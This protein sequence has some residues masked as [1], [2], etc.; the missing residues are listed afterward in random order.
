MRRTDGT[1][2]AWGDNREGQL[3]LGSLA[4]SSSPSR[5]VGLSGVTEIAAGGRR[6]FARS[7]S[8]LLEWGDGQFAPESLGTDLSLASLGGE[9]GSDRRDY[10][11]GIARAFYAYDPQ[12]NVRALADESGALTDTYTYDAFGNLLAGTH[13]GGLPGADLAFNPYL[14][15][16]ERY[17]AAA[18]LYHLR[19][20]DCDPLLGR[21]Q[22]LDSFAGVPGQPFSHNR[23][24]YSEADPVNLHDPS[25]HYAVT[26]WQ[27]VQLLDQQVAYNDFLADIGPKEQLLDLGALTC[28]Y[29]YVMGQ[30]PQ[31]VQ[32]ERPVWLA[33]A[34]SGSILG[35]L[36]NESGSVNAGTDGGNNTR[37]LGAGSSVF[38]LAQ[39]GAPFRQSVV[40]RLVDSAWLATQRAWPNLNT[41]P[42]LPDDFR[43]KLSLK[44]QNRWPDV[45]YHNAILQGA[46]RSA[47]LGREV[48]A[49]VTATFRPPSILPKTRSALALKSLSGTAGGGPLD[50]RAPAA[51]AQGAF[52]SHVSASGFEYG[53]MEMMREWTE[54]VQSSGAYRAAYLWA[55]VGVRL[56][57]ELAYLG[58]SMVS[59]VGEGMDVHSAFSGETALER[60]LAW[61][62]LGASAATGGLSPN[63]G[64]VGRAISEIGGEL[65]RLGRRAAQVAGHGTTSALRAAERASLAA[66]R[67]GALAVGSLAGGVRTAG[68]YAAAFEK[69]YL[70][71]AAKYA[72]QLN[73]GVDPTPFFHG[74]IEGAREARALHNAPRITAEVADTAGDLARTERHAT[75]A[76]ADAAESGMG[77][78]YIASDA[79]YLPEM[80]KT[81]TIPPNPKGTYFSLDK[82]D[83]ALTASRLQ[84]PHDAAIRAEFGLAQLG[85]DIRVP[86][87]NWGKGPHLEPITRDFPDFGFGGASQRIT[88]SGVQLERVI[89]T[90]TGAVLF[91]R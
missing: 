38:F 57:G 48:E 45:I 54:A 69:G 55:E 84:V 67:K 86:L 71:G 90:R 21:F 16:G 12:G 1:V 20:R 39:T 79:K 34:G 58:A 18:G 65:G 2:L 68:N 43:A 7:G 82:M 23:Y 32:R 66:A 27:A 74:L 37:G 15:Q 64:R 87:G 49:Y 78:R 31:V 62:S 6:S 10:G 30:R 80:I 19:A 61:F 52:L 28:N 72:G 47:L 22:Q 3:G 53:Q 59:G 75:A 88:T 85:D 56:P 81:G 51:S 63:F 70:R 40:E 4:E 50:W 91:Q 35:D 8:A 14:F 76:L 44:W 77:Y 42:K 17:E 26:V 41:G 25:G 13:A 11:L 60:N 73:C 33:A 83:D 29:A 5:I 46:L 24:T 36:G 89:D 9:A